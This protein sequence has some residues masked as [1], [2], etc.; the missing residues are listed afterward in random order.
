MICGFRLPDGPPAENGNSVPRE[1]PGGPVAPADN[2]GSASEASGAQPE[3]PEWRLELS[4]RLQEIKLR[5]EGGETGSNS[6]PAEDP[7][8]LS[9][10]RKAPESAEAAPPKP[11]PRPRRA[12]RNLGRILPLDSD[13]AP[14]PAAAAAAIE[15]GF[16]P[17][18]TEGGGIPEGPDKGGSPAKAEV[19]KMPGDSNPAKA[20]FESG[21]LAWRAGP[22][23]A[24]RIEKEINDGRPPATHG[25]APAEDIR[26]LIDKLVA[27]QASQPPAALPDYPAAAQE[28]FPDPPA[29]RTVEPGPDAGDFILLPNYPPEGKLILLSRTLAGLVDHV[30]ILVCGSAFIFAVDVLEGIDVVDSVS[31]IHYALLMLATYFVYSLFFLGTGSQTIGMMLTDLRVVGPGGSRPSLPQIITRCCTFLLGSAVLG[32]GLIWGFFDRQARCLHDR[33]SGS[34]VVRISAG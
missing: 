3:I 34:H 33:L 17:G 28:L 22:G 16:S 11:A 7:G 4:R 13:P 23:G 32:I 2:P 9:P 18:V 20:H 1:G 5:R 25:A 31:M 30:I 15:P 26:E 10:T 19:P 14:K 8:D 6:A 24:G 29:G 27:G 21:G 12:A